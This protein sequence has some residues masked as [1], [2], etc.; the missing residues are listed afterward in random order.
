MCNVIMYRTVQQ[1]LGF[2]LRFITV[3]LATVT[4]DSVANPKNCVIS[5]INLFVFDIPTV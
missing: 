3:R 1:H 5:L 4:V 2:L